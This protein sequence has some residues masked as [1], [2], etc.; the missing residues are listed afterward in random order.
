MTSRADASP[1]RG[2][3]RIRR[4]LLEVRLVAYRGLWDKFAGPGTLGAFERARRRGIPFLVDLDAAA[5]TVPD[6]LGQGL[7]DQAE[8]PLFLM[9]SALPELTSSLSEQAVGTNGNVCVIERRAEGNRFPIHVAT[10]DGFRR[11]GSYV[12]L[13]AAER[14]RD[15]SAAS[16]GELVLYESVDTVQ[17]L[18]SMRAGPVRSDETT[19]QSL[20]FASDAGAVVMR[21]SDLVEREL[22]LNCATWIA[23]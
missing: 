2:D 8:V 16:D 6:L 4:E 1:P 14:L 11:C 17:S 23:R 9:S 5:V 3:M 21:V 12:P 19:E 7:L 22:L 10:A 20:R 18:D 15:Q 13:A